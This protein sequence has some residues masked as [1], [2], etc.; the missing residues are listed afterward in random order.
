MDVKD[1][2]LAHVKSHLQM[3]RTVKTTDQPAASGQSDGSGE[4]DMS[5]MGST[6]E[7]DSLPGFTDHQRGPPD[8]TLQQETDFSSTTTTPSSNSSRS[9][10]TWL[11]AK[12][13]N[14][15]G[16]RTSAAPFQQRSGHRIKESELGGVK[17]CYLGFDLDQKNPSLEFTL[18]R[19][20]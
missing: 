17:S 9:R 7:G 16:I 10:E 3:Y 15:D 13:N 5:I 11:Q 18:G 14:V 8:G 12:S 2:T 1:L 4:E 6:S 19:P 20:D